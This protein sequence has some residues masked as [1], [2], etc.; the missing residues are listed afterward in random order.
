MK[1]ITI[2][3]I[4]GSLP[5]AGSGVNQGTKVEVW[6]PQQLFRVVVVSPPFATL[7]PDSQREKRNYCSNLLQLLHTSGFG[8]VYHRDT[9]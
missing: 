1:R 2:R 9:Y 5:F 6:H 4:A 7:M 3:V 8:T